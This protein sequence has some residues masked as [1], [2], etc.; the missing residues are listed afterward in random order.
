MAHVD[1]S[2]VK[3]LSY[4]NAQDVAKGVLARFDAGEFDVATI[5]YAKFVNVV[6]QTP[7]AQQIIPAAYETAEGADAGTTVYD[8]EPPRKASLPT[9]CRAAWPHRSSRLSWKMRPPS[10]VRAC[11]QWTTRHATQAI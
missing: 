8:Y 9:C 10:K 2:E 7:T 11:P 5:F 3:N 1:F 6:S 4:A